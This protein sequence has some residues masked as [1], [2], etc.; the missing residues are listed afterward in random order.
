MKQL[1]FILISIMVLTL[2]GCNLLYTESEEKLSGSEF[3]DDASA[4]D[5]NSFVNS[6]YAVLR[7]ATMQDAAYFLLG[8]DLRCAPVSTRLNTNLKDGKWILALTENRLNDLRDNYSTGDY[9]SGNGIMDWQEMY[10]VIQTANILIKEVDRT[11]LSDTE[12][13]MS[14]AEAVFARC[15]TYFLLVR[16]LGDVPYYTN[17]Y[18]NTPLP[19]TDMVTVLKNIAAELQQLLDSDPDQTI[20]PMTRTGGDKAIKASRGAVLALLMHVDMWL[21]GFDESNATTYYNNVVDCGKELVDNNGGAYALV[22][23]SQV[24]NSLF[25]G[26]SSEGIFEI[27]QNITYYSGG[28]TFLN[29]AIFSNQVMYKPFQTKSYPNIYYTYDFLS[30]VYPYGEA[31]SRVQ[32]WFDENM[33]TTMEDY[34]FKEILKFKNVDTYKNSN[35]VDVTT[36]NSGNFVLFRL[37]DAILLYAEALADLGTD[38]AKACELINKVRARANASAVQA[39]GQELKDAVYWERV[40]ELIGEGQY[41]YDLVRTRKI[42]DGNYCWHTMTR[43]NFNKGAWTWPISRTALDNNTNMELNSY[44]E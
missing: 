7:T 29:D 10:E 26:A 25:K 27:V 36:T 39:S 37:A 5:V 43:S 20:L 44:W 12:K 19:R 11:S 16:N 4:S 24:T 41:Y 23:M 14:K 33:Y 21:A 28:E 15:L 1:S 8:G 40:R 30:K 31:D 3:W 2:S 34:T 35:N 22:P 18:N 17:A 6:M 42:F 13:R 9:R 38:D 32:S